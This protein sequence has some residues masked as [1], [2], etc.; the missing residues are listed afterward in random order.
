MRLEGPSADQAGGVAGRILQRGRDQ[1][2]HANLDDPQQKGEEGQGH[3][4]EF[5]GRRAIL[6]A[7]EPAYGSR[8]FPTLAHRDLV[9]RIRVLAGGVR[10]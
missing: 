1:V 4:G 10:R 9:A 5:D 6:A 2:D 3:K 7:S 8:Q